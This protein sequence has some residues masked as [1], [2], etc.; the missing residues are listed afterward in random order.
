MTTSVSR[1]VLLAPACTGVRAPSGTIF[2]SWA[3]AQSARYASLLQFDRF[4]CFP[5]AFP[6]RLAE[7]ENCRTSMANAIARRVVD[8]GLAVFHVPSW[9]PDRSGVDEAWNRSAWVVEAATGVRVRPLI[10]R[11]G[12]RIVAAPDCPPAVLG[13]LDRARAS[14]ELSLPVDVFGAPMKHR[15][16]GAIESPTGI[17]CAV[18][19]FSGDGAWLI[20][21]SDA[22]AHDAT[23][24]GA[25]AGLLDVLDLMRG[26]VGEAL[27]PKGRARQARPRVGT[28]LHEALV[29]IE[30]A[31]INKFVQVRDRRV[32]QELKSKYHIPIEST[33]A[34]RERGEEVPTGAK[35]YRRV[36]GKAG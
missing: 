8:G 25:S 2:M 36:P 4:V 29:A 15:V 11:R 34:A 26:R 14:Y 6:R 16:L 7:I 10:G 19:G 22:S 1:T 31:P 32:I 9:R 27:P 35:G 17:P 12:L 23:E 21:P 24:C 33:A 3:R 30:R 13:Q 18:V 5:A 28:K 20:L